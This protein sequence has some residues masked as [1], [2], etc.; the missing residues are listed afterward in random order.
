LKKQPS[1]TREK[2]VSIISLD[3]QR[4]VGSIFEAL[5]HSSPTHQGLRRQIFRHLA[6][7]TKLQRMFL[8]VV[9]GHPDIQR[10]VLQELAK[11][12][13]L[14]RKLVVVANEHKRS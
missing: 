5:C 9:S 3:D 13:Q 7:S 10:A 14:K 1:P 4:I 2:L 8:D 11:K 12:P 6:K